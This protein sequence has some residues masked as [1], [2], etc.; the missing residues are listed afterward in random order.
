MADK[1]VIHAWD[2]TC[3]YTIPGEM[4]HDLK[5]EFEKEFSESDFGDMASA[6]DSC[7]GAYNQ[8]RIAPA[9]NALLDRWERIAA[10][11]TE[12]YQLLNPHQFTWTGTLPNI[13]TSELTP[14]Q[15]ALAEEAAN[16]VKFWPIGTILEIERFN[17]FNYTLAEIPARANIAKETIEGA[18]VSER[19]TSHLSELWIGL[20]ELCQRHNIPTSYTTDLDAGR[21][22]SIICRLAYRISAL[23]P[24]NMRPVSEKALTEQFVRQ[25]ARQ[26]PT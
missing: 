12:L 15:F 24:E 21:R 6:L 16:R 23:L 9:P 3:I 26:S 11:A 20:T 19:G 13:E 22:K 4:R 8:Y 17:A 14:G 5:N 18:V 1:K 10:V 7:H 2:A 25:K